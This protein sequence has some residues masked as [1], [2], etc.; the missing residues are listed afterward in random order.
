MGKREATDAGWLACT[1]PDSMLSNLRTASARKLRLFACACCHRVWHLL[2]EVRSREAVAAAEKWA[3]GLLKST[4]LRVFQKAAAGTLTPRRRGRSSWAA[5]AAAQVAI[6]RKQWV[7]ITAW[8]CRMALEQRVVEEKSHCKLLRD[9]F[10]IPWRQVS[11][12]LSWLS[13]QCNTVVHLAQTIYEERAFDRMPILA[14]ALED[15]GCDNI[16]ILAHCR[17]PGEHVR[18]CWVVDL[19]LCKS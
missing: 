5:R 4:E 18:G 7:G 14:D 6:P 17:Q 10:G 15:A 2:P 16:D 9:I 3:D 1:N 11:I 12:D 13:W 8:Y 19:L